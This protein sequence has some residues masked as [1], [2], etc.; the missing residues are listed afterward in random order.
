M[1]GELDRGNTNEY[2]RLGIKLKFVFQKILRN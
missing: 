2:M 1:K